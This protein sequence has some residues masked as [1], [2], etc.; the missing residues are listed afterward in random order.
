MRDLNQTTRLDQGREIDPELALRRP[1][2]PHRAKLA[3]QRCEGVAVAARRHFQTNGD[4]TLGL[5]EGEVTPVGENE[6]E[7]LPMVGATRCLPGAL[8]Q[9]DPEI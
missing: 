9:D 2:H 1:H 8:H 4:P 5:L 6:R 3:D 7:L